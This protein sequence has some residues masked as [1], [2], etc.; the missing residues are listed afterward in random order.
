MLLSVI[1]RNW[2]CPR[3]GN[4]LLNQ[5]KFIFD[6]RGSVPNTYK[7]CIASHTFL[8]LF[9]SIEIIANPGIHMKGFMLVKT[10][11]FLERHLYNGQL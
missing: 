4:D 5:L 3:N 2:S 1:T 6:K 11:F 9:D 8:S 10:D 7:C